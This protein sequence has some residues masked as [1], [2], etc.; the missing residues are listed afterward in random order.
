LQPATSPRNL[1]H[2]ARGAR[3]GSAV[4][5]YHL[6]VKN[7]SRGDGR[8]AVAAAAYRAGETLPNE[9]EERDSAF[10]GRRDVLHSEIRAPVGAP[11][12][13]VDRARLWNAVEAAEKRKDARLAK[14]IEYALPR[15]LPRDLWLAVARELADAYASKGFVADFAIHADKSMENPHVHMMLTT[16]ALA[17]D[18]FGGK[19]READ[20]LK[21]VTEARALWAR[22]A[23]AALG[24]IG[25]GVEIDARSHSA[26]GITHQPTT[27]RG[28]DKAERRARRDRA[29]QGEAMDKNRDHP[30]PDPS[31][32]ERMAAL[33]EENRA[34]REA[35]AAKERDAP[36]PD[37]DGRPIH[38][39]ALRAAENEMLR[40]A[41]KPAREVPATPRPERL[42]AAER[43]EA[44]EAVDRQ[45][46]IEVSEREA[47]AYRI[48]PHENHLD[49]LAG[50]S[51]AAARP[52]S[53]ERGAREDHLDWLRPEDRTTKPQQQEPERD[54]ER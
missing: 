41:E 8:S 21:F 23:N 48:A 10:G 39:D 2:I 31:E 30:E 17:P 24:K 3:A 1:P 44:R 34:L 47:D 51:P 19:L 42:D 38:P 46:A 27:H 18:G 32:R 15:E 43:L 49:W 36:V 45:S 11:G 16:R 35:L 22:I 12:W 33:E 37:P 6:H 26:R 53:A 52:D 5:I 54:R 14:E 7:I 50:A 28:P 4:A 13:M 9:L 25:A 29:A 20:G 40:D